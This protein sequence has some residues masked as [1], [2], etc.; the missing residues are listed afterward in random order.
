MRTG[1]LPVVGDLT[2]EI[3]PVLR[4]F[5]GRELQIEYHVK[6]DVLT[7]WDSEYYREPLLEF[8]EWDLMGGDPPRWI[9]PR[10]RELIR[11]A[12]MRF[13]E[14]RQEGE[15]DENIDAAE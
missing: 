7:D 10:R 11:D 13:S 6:S 9:K 14:F 15:L 3:H 5:K 8:L 4:R 12:S 1:F 2:T